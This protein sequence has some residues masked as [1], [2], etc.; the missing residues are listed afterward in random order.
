MMATQW[1]TDLSASLSW[2]QRFWIFFFA[3]LIVTIPIAIFLYFYWKRLLR[4]SLVSDGTR[5]M[6]LEESGRKIHPKIGKMFFHPGAVTSIAGAHKQTRSKLFLFLAIV[7]LPLFSVSGQLGALSILF[8]FFF[9]AF[10]QNSAVTIFNPEFHED[11]LFSR[12]ATDS[13]TAIKLKNIGTLESSKFGSI[14][15]G[16]E[17]SSAIASYHDLSSHLELYVDRPS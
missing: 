5:L 17:D 13:L 3:I 14:V 16:G 9:M 2:L 15:F 1:R 8:L 12:P 4:P 11:S 10:P 6:L 7:T